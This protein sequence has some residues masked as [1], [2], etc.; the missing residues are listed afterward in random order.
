MG[1]LEPTGEC[2]AGYFCEAGAVESFGEVDES[3]P[4]GRRRV[5]LCPAGF[6]CIEGAKVP[7][8]CPVGTY[9]SG[10]NSVPWPCKAGTYNLEAMQS[11][12]KPCPAGFICSPVIFIES[13]PSFIEGAISKLKR[14]ISCH[15]VSFVL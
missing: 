10:N 15:L 12:C 4:S 9:C 8:A 6:Y 13:N 5:L 14:L 7:M 2:L 1:L 11:S 3:I